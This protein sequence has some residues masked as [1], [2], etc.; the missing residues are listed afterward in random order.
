[1][2][3]TACLINTARGGLVDHRALAH[4]LDGGQLAGAA[5]DVQDPE[6][7][8]LSLP[9]F[10]HPRVIVTPH[11][12]FVSLESLAELRTRAARQVAACLTGQTPEHVVNPSVL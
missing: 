6:P 11:A 12:A 10:N 8:D 7:P 1:M 3:P 4:A 5:L 9:P 2:K